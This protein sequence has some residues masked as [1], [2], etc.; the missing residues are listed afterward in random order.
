MKPIYLSKEIQKIAG[1][2]Y[3]AI[4]PRDKG[5]CNKIGMMTLNSLNRKLLLK[6]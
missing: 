1:L 2:T 5:I 6:L 3:P 4:L